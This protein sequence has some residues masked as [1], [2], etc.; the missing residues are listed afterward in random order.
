MIGHVS[1]QY[2]S[3]VLTEA[4]VN[5]HLRVILNFWRLFSLP[6]TSDTLAIQD[7]SSFVIEEFFESVDPR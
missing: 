3:T 7:I 4:F 6:T 2:S 1:A 5:T